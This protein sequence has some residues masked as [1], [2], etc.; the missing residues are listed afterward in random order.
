[1][2]PTP[3]HNKSLGAT[4]QLVFAM[5]AVFLLG[6]TLRAQPVNAQVSSKKVQIGVPFE[7]AVVISVAATNFSPP[8]FRDFEVVGGP[9]QSNSVQYVNGVMSQ[10]TVLSYALVARREG[11]YTIGPATVLSNNQRLETQP[12]VVEVVKG[13]PGSDPQA[14]TRVTGEDVFIRT[15]VSKSSC[16]I[17]EQILIT[18]KIYSRYGIV[19][20]KK[21]TP[22]AYDGFYAESLES[23]SNGVPATENVDGVV[24]YTYEIFR[25]NATAN[26]AGKITIS[27]MSA[28]LVIR[29]QSNAKPRNLYEQFFGAPAYEDIAVAAKSR[30]LVVNV[31]DLPE[32]GKPENFHGAVGNFTYKAQAS[33]TELRA[34]DA[35]NLKLTVSGKGNL[36][37][38][39]APQLKLP[40]S[41]E[42]YEPKTS[43]TGTTKTFDYLVI[44]REAGEFTLGDLDFSFF[45][46][47]TK[48]YTTLPAPVIRINVLP[49]DPNAS[50]AQVFSPHSQVKATENDIRYIKKGNFLMLRSDTEFFNSLA[51][52][53]T[54]LGILMALLVALVLRRR[55]IR[56]TSDQV[57][58]RNRRAARLAK[59]QLAKAESFMARND[60]DQFYTEVLT[61]LN[62]YVSHKLNIPV[63]ELSREAIQSALQR[64]QVDPAV[65]Q[66]L[67]GTL[68]TC[69]YAKYAPGAVSGDLQAVY[70]DTAGLVTAIEQQLSIKR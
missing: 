46:L 70:R 25:T 48:R 53:G 21:V 33:K 10:Q 37:L 17:G 5:L 61:A 8:S 45:N 58:V 3:T 1:M 67:L 34:N 13:A 20:L 15:N 31:Q 39:S 57:A 12:V 66:K 65:V 64:R 23:T 69:E 26:K 51:H 43:Q 9:N 68:D 62:N 28:E 30:P 16:Y 59:K 40:Q 11:K 56:S 47:D 18:Q 24:Y 44:P 32:N 55:Y 35:F 4:K 54:L 50:G 38:L 42:T 29:K 27:P 60:K 41:F 22:P 63:A 2:Q 52:I 6:S 7:Y 14:A 36:A 19:G 49:P